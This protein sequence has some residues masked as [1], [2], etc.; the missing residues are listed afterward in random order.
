ML[1]AIL[2][3]LVMHVRVSFCKYV[4]SFLMYKNIRKGKTV[5]GGS[6]YGSLFFGSLLRHLLGALSIVEHHLCEKYM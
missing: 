3:R 2:I 4:L 5:R 6:N 1:G